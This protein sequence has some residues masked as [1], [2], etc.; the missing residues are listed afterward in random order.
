MAKHLNINKLNSNICAS[1]GG[2]LYKLSSKKFTANGRKYL[3]LRGN[4]SLTHLQVQLQTRISLTALCYFQAPL[5]CFSCLCKP[6][7]RVH[8]A[9][10]QSS[11]LSDTPLYAGVCSHCVF[12]PLLSTAQKF[13]PSLNFLVILEGVSGMSRNAP[14]FCREVKWPCF[15]LTSWSDHCGPESK[16]E[17]AQTLGKFASVCRAPSFAPAYVS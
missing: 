6:S 11:T 12:F 15:Y 1:S 16:A 13:S 9:R 2:I 17:Q 8:T 3:V 7:T 5:Q 10:A 4:P 14:L